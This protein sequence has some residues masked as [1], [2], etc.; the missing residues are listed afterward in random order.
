[1]GESDSVAE[2]EFKRASRELTEGVR[3][4]ESELATVA[5]SC[6][7]PGV[8]AIDCERLARNA[9]VDPSEGGRTTETAF[10]T[11]PRS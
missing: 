1:V 8:K 2:R 3:T 6:P 10:V 7:T 4:T 11:P 5:R 9:A